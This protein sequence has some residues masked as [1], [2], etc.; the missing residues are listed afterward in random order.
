MEKKETTFAPEINEKSK[1][2][3]RP[4]NIFESLYAMGKDKVAQSK[5]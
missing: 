1:T 3:V 4:E 2:L 5:V